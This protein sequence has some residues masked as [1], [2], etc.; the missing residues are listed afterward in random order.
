MFGLIFKKSLSILIWIIGLTIFLLSFFLE[1]QNNFSPSQESENEVYKNTGFT[2][3]TKTLRNL[4]FF[5][6]LTFFI[7]LF[8]YNH[9]S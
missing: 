5:L 2:K 8:L 3:L 4:Y 7:L 6:L 9:F 1:E